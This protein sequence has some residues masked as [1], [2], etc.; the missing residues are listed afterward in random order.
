MDPY[1]SAKKVQMKAELF[2]L[3]PVG[4]QSQQVGVPG[5][6]ERGLRSGYCY[7]IY[8]MRAALTKFGS[9]HTPMVA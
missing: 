9:C 6:V 3:F 5:T 2:S 1:P 8:I 4:A 7:V